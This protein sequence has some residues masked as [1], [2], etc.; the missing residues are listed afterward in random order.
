MGGVSEGRA[1]YITEDGTAFVRLIGTV[2][3][4]NN[5]GFLQVRRLLPLGLPAGTKGL[6]L[7]TRGNGEAYYV[8]LR[9][10]EMTRPWYFYKAAF[11]STATWTK[12]RIPLSD[13]EP[14]KT[15]HAKLTDPESVVSIGFVA[16]GRDHSADLS[17]ASVGVY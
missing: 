17:I 2:S 1:D 11:Q 12:L 5:G 14:S 8:F 13:F 9:T 7:E 10:R 16:Y 3:T 6:E 4:E 15:F